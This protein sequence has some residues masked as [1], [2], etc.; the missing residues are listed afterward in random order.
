MDDSGYS[1]CFQQNLQEKN[2]CLALKKDRGNTSYSWQQLKPRSY[3]SFVKGN[4]FVH[5][6]TLSLLLQECLIKIF[7]TNVGRF[8]CSVFFFPAYEL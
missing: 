8:Y 4:N 6:K 7:L 2:G 3:Y 5:A 1:F